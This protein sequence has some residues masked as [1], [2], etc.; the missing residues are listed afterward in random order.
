VFRDARY[1]VQLVCLDDGGSNPT[2]VFGGIVVDHCNF[3]ELGRSFVRRASSPR[4][5]NIM[6]WPLRGRFAR[7]A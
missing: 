6:Y 2:K 3:S 4:G 7:A 5:K 1:L